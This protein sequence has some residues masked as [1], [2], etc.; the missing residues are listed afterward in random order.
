MAR[1]QVLEPNE[2]GDIPS[3]GQFS[4][5]TMS[6][7]LE[8]YRQLAQNLCAATNLPQSA[9]GSFADHPSSA[10]AM[11]ASEAAL[12]DEAEYQWRI[13]TA[14]LRRT[15]QNIIMVRDKLD[16]P[17]AESWKTSVKWTPARYSSPASAADFAVKMVSAFPSLQES[18][19]LMRRAGL[20]E[21]DLADINAENRKKNAVSLLDRALAATNNENVVDENA[22]N[23]TNSDAAN[24]DGDDNV[25]SAGNNNGG[26]GSGN[27]LNLN[28]APNT[29]NRVKRNIKLPGVTKTPIN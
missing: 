23:A 17:P 10:E 15:L 4:Q 27:N 11:Q 16:E 7:H 26:N 25:N 9:I 2:N 28:N 22:E 21:D 14:P 12:A 8:M 24:N 19:T 5:M 18:Q 3:G 13:F 20:T 1:V 29:R 6:P